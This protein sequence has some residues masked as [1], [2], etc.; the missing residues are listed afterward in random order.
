MRSQ[1][2]TGPLA[3][4]LG[5]RPHRLA[6]LTRDRLI[7]PPKSPTGSFLWDHHHACRAAELLGV[8]APS[9]ED[10]CRLSQSACW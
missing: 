10:F 8:P 6:Y 2:S 3:D 5:V 7:R 9:L 4:L 1:V